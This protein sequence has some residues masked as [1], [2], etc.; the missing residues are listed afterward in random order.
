MA[1]HLWMY[2]R[3]GFS[4]P[5]RP[6]APCWTRRC[7]MTSALNSR[8]AVYCETLHIFGENQVPLKDYRTTMKKPEGARRKKCDGS[9]TPFEKRSASISNFMLGSS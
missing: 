5:S 4:S 2:I 9:R 3:E 8:A 6:T 7:L 1:H